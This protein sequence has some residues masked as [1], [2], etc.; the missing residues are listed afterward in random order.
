[1]AAK[2]SKW[3]QSNAAGWLASFIQYPFNYL[4]LIVTA[5]VFSIL[6]ERSTSEPTYQNALLCAVLFNVLS[7]NIYFSS[8]RLAWKG[9]LKNGLLVLMA[10][11]TIGLFFLLPQEDNSH[12]SDIFYSL[13]L[14][15][16]GLILLPAVLPEHDDE[17]I[18]FK[19]NGNY[20]Y[21]FLES[22][23]VTFLLWGLL[24]LSILAFNELFE[25]RGGQGKI[26]AHLFVWLMTVL[27]AFLFLS[28]HKR[29][30]FFANEFKYEGVNQMLLTYV[31]IP[32][33]LVYA[34][35][36][37][38]FFIKNILTQSGTAIWLQDLS[39]WFI[40]LS[41]LTYLLAQ[42]SLNRDTKIISLYRKIWP[43]LALP[44][45]LALSYATY[46]RLKSTGIS[47]ENYF[48]ALFV[49]FGW[50]II[51]II[52]LRKKF[53]WIPAAA[54]FLLLFAATGGPW[55]AWTLS[56][57]NMKEHVINGLM[58]SGMIEDGKFV[59]K[60]EQPQIS[61][62][63]AD[64]IYELEHRK[65]LGFLKS[66]DQDGQ[67]FANE[68]PSAYK[69]ISRVSVNEEKV[70]DVRGNVNYYREFL[71]EITP[72]F[73]ER[74][75]PIV[76]EFSQH[77]TLSNKVVIKSSALEL[78][79]EGEKKATFLPD[80]EMMETLPLVVLSSGGYQ[81]RLFLT[82]YTALKGKNL[83]HEAIYLQGIALLST[84]N[85]SSE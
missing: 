38:S 51:I 72:A 34:L 9:L 35:I 25:I 31:L 85:D 23:L 66:Y 1:M 20:F 45:M 71:P 61:D 60:T 64:Q 54:I 8:E 42:P 69:I 47:L 67:I 41:G 11:V 49:M 17:K 73:G 82:Q 57:N 4:G 58:E 10:A 36:L 62:A 37:I 16:L 28:R 81:L 5:I 13:W 39:I 46:S 80:D 52:Q 65:L 3:I 59:L 76:T 44:V 29:E 22:F 33:S 27:F 18:F 24:S 26:Y 83:Q 40:V 14:I 74:I 79:I 48:R 30:D 78:Y 7:T 75:I 43:Y 12:R 21:R 63:L 56:K 68:E 32:S 53:Y 6:I 70:R 2:I 15:G 19:F 55:R 84:Y 77:D 50:T